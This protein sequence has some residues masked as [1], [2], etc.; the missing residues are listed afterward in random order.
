MLYTTTTS[1]VHTTT[2]TTP[3][4]RTGACMYSIRL[5]SGRKRKVTGRKSDEVARGDIRLDKNLF[6]FCSDY[7]QSTPLTNCPY[8]LVDDE[9]RGG[10]GS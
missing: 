9:G 2:T 10:G 3:Y 6:L 8:L 7:F 1:D 5:Q 4:I